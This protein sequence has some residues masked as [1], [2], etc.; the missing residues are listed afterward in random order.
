[1]RPPII[2]AF[3]HMAFRYVSAVR[4]KENARNTVHNS[5]ASADA[6][7]EQKAIEDTI[8]QHFLLVKPIPGVGGGR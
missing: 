3:H 8:A 1:M 7:S 6:L 5:D 4:R 2:E